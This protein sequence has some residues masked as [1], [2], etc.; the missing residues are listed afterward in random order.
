MKKYLSI[1]FLLFNIDNVNAS[2]K[3]NIITNLKN[4]NN[5]SFNFEQ[6][7]NGKTE[8]G[9]CII[10]YPKKIFCEYKLES[11][12][13]LVSNG[14][15]LVIKTGQSHYIYPLKKTI[16]NIILDKNFLLAKIKKAKEYEINNEIISLKFLEN[17]QEIKLFFDKKNYDLIGWQS[18]DIYQNLSI[19]SIISL[20]KNV[21]IKEN[22]FKLP[23]QE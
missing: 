5:L 11:K 12:K 1:F 3:E 2:N 9:N 4:I 14:K 16:L 20:S 7:I 18:T 22:I 17:E 23:K 15:Y 13:I 10:E 19:T 21:F 6:N 8:K